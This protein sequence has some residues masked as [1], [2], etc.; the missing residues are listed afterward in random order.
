MKLRTIIAYLRG[1]YVCIRE[2]LFEKE[3]QKLK[4]QK[5][6]AMS[7]FPWQHIAVS[8]LQRKRESNLI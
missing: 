6:L 2:K 4:D 7:K 5:D 8:F 3:K 1:T